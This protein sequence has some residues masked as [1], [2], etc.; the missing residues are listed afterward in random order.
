MPLY[1]YAPLGISQEEYDAWEQEV[2]EKHEKMGCFWARNIYWYVDQYSCVLILR[3][4]LWFSAAVPVL[5]QLWNT[6]E[7]ERKTGFAHRAPKKK[8]KS[9]AADSAGGSMMEFVNVVKLTA[10]ATATPTA[11]ST[12]SGTGTV[13][14]N[15]T[16]N[17]AMRPSDVLM[18][19]FKIDDLDMV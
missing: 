11:P 14:G 10:G 16:S 3:N 1:E 15:R 2:F 19:C 4:R 6:I 17:A 9:A 5:Q 7:K 13:P 18:K 8:T 12:G